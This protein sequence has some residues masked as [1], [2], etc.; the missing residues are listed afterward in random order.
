MNKNSEN[1]K[2]IE[3]RLKRL[4]HIEETFQKIRKLIINKNN[5]DSLIAHYCNLLVE[6]G[7]YASSWIILLDDNKI[8]S[9]SAQSGIKKEFPALLNQFMKKKLMHAHKLL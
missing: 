6:T 1:Q 4:H 9:A 3:M 8:P 7:S 2:N 5:L